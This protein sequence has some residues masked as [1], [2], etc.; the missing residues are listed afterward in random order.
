MMP[1]IQCVPTLEHLMH[2]N[3]KMSLHYSKEAI[4]QCLEMVVNILL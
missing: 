4:N 1:G 3:F 2:N